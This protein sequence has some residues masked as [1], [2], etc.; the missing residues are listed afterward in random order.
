MMKIL[1]NDGLA[2]PGAKMLEEAG[3]IINYGKI[4]Q[5]NLISEI[6]REK[7]EALLVRSTTEVDR[8]LIDSCPSI[9]FI[10]RGGAAMDHIDAEYAL[11]KGIKVLNT[12]MDSAPSVAEL[13]FAHIFSLS[14]KLYDSNRNFPQGHNF[15]DLKEKYNQGI[16]LY[17]KTIGIIGFGRVGQEVAKRALG[18]GM[19]VIA[20]DPFVA[21]A[22]LKLLIPNYQDIY[23]SIQTI[24]L[25]KVLK[26]SDFVTLHLPLPFDKKPI[27]NKEQ[28]NLMK[29]GVILINVSKGDLINEEDLIE[30]LN[31]GKIASAG[32]D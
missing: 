14:R 5:K 16:E 30:A 2:S 8:N 24:S 20:S 22:N 7:Y 9:K 28:I 3:F 1:A 27:I 10:A 25:E 6:N 31:S 18:L 32:I 15:H 21:D 4:P 23:I 29:D 17:N 26:N 19:N 11:E 12:P 13:A